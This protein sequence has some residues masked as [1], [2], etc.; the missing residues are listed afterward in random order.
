M[1]CALARQ[2]PPRGHFLGF[3]LGAEVLRN[4][5]RGECT[6]S[7]PASRH[8]T[9]AAAL[10]RLLHVKLRADEPGAVVH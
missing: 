5:S 6:P 4:F 3:L 10:R 9:P 1:G 7:R 2:F 8:V